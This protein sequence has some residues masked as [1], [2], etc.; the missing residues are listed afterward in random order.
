MLSTWL[1]GLNLSASELR[2]RA[3]REPYSRRRVRLFA[4]ADVRDGKQVETVASA[5]NVQ[6][7]TVYRWLREAAVGG[8]DSA[9]KGK[10]KRTLNSTRRAELAAWISRGF[11]PSPHKFEARIPEADANPVFSGRVQLLANQSAK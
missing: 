1:E 9:Q 4:I 2:A 6:P 11:K 7:E 5:I 3:R 8:L 10:S